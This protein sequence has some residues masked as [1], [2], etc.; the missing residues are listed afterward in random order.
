MNDPFTFT[1]CCLRCGQ[2]IWHSRIDNITYCCCE[3]ETPRL[4]FREKLQL[5]IAVEERL[6]GRLREVTC[7][8]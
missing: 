8:D 6:R 3:P 1:V 4:G 2:R 7:H 5:R